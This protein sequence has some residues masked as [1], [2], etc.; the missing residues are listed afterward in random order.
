MMS[1]PCNLTICQQVIS[2]TP[3]IVNEGTDVIF[4]GGEFYKQNASIVV[5]TVTIV[6]PKARA[7]EETP[8]YVWIML[9]VSGIM[10]VIL[11]ILLFMDKPKKGSSVLR[12][13]RKLQSQK[14]PPP[15][16]PP[17]ESTELTE[18]VDY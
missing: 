3:G 17:P 10:F 8:F 9:G 5:P 1:Q 16:P 11:V 2:S 14:S 15:P 13:I 12:Q 4:C 18:Y 7:T 6:P